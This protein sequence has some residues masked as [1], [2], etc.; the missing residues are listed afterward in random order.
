MNLQ[1]ITDFFPWAESSSATL[2]NQFTLCL[3]RCSTSGEFV[4]L[5]LLLKFIKEGRQ[6]VLVSCN[7]TPSHYI[8]ILRKNVSQVHLQFSSIYAY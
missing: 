6:V 4:F 1:K 3:D 7:H 2:S 5:Y 8:S